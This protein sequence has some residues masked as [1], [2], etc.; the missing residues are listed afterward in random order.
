MA[1]AFFNPLRP[2]A[3]TL[4]CG[5]TAA[6]TLKS[7]GE[8]GMQR[9]DRNLCTSLLVAAILVASAGA[10]AR[11]PA[12]LVIQDQGS[13]YA[14]GK[15]LTAP[16]TFDPNGWSV[17]TN[18]P[19]GQTLHCDHAYASYQVPVNPRVLPLVMWH[20]NEETG[21]TWETTPDGREGFQNIFLRRG[22]PV[23]L[24]DQPR[25]GRA[26]RSCEPITLTP[27]YDDQSAVFGLFR[28]GNWPDYFPGLAFKNDAETWHEFNRWRTPNTGPFDPVVVSDGVAAV[29][30]R[31]GPGILVTH[32]QSGGP[33]WLTAMKSDKVRAIVSFEPGSG[34][35]FPE[36]ELPTPIPGSFDTLAGRP[37]PPSDFGRLA[38]IPILIIYGDNI[39]A[40][41]TA[42]PGQDAWRVRL[43]MAR[44]WRDAVNGKGGDVTI[45]H[46]PERGLRGN[47]HFPFSDL[48][49]DKVAD[50]MSAWLR[51][52]RLDRRVSR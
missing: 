11:K 16:G 43:Q 45:I 3:C 21:K 42:S 52:K 31:I 19:A 28:L 29:F 12:P 51:D 27:P 20:G 5:V 25:R 39:P 30:D 46:L 15:V 49:N 1:V 36:G 24:V 41:R 17:T 32:S 37:V 50:V 48:N 2:F 6:L 40:E 23:Y 10:E 44:L 22:F 47:T 13:F 33:G 34:F 4:W 8:E 14:G 7:K 26:G 18:P 9:E 35:T 38:R